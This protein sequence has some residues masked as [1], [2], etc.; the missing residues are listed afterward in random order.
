MRSLAICLVALTLAAC[1]G[2]RRDEG[3]GKAQGEILP[4]SVSDAMLPVDTVRSQA[5][6]AP[7]AQAS[8]KAKGE[9]KAEV[10]ADGNRA[11]EPKLNSIDPANE[12]SGQD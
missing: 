6:L 7:A 11:E 10:S 9:E 4:A 12:G 2:D 5:P 3:A 1:G 8:G